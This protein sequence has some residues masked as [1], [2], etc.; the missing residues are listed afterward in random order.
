[1]RSKAINLVGRS[2][3]RQRRF[4][5]AWSPLLKQLSATQAQIKDSNIVKTVRKKIM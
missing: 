2:F 1:M 3:P 5:A 4:P